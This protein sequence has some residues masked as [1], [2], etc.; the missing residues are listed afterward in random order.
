M[1]SRKVRSVATAPVAAGLFGS[2]LA[3]GSMLTFGAVAL[4]DPGPESA[5]GVPCSDM[6]QQLAA[7]A[8]GAARP[9]VV[10]AAPVA[11]LPGVGAPATDLAQVAA[12]VIE[13]PPLPPC[14]MPSRPRLMLVFS[15]NPQARR[16]NWRTRRSRPSVVAVAVCRYRCPHLQAEVEIYPRPPRLSLTRRR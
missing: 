8:P 11:V 12:D 2:I 3:V 16:R 7:A 6:V 4:A 15:G 9:P 10:D 5:P 1:T 13:A 14:R